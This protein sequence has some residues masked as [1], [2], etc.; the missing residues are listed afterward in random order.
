MAA[1]SSDEGKP[2][3]TAKPRK[4]GTSCAAD[5]V[6]LTSS[7][8]KT[9]K[10]TTP[11]SNAAV[12]APCK[13]SVGAP[14]R[15]RFAPLAPIVPLSVRPPPNSSNTPPLRARFDVGPAD[16][17][18]GH[19]RDDRGQRGGRVDVVRDAQRTSQRRRANPARRREDEYDRGAALRTGP[20]RCR[21]AIIRRQAAS[22]QR[23]TKQQKE[24]PDHQ[25]QQKQHQ[26]HAEAQ[27]FGKAGADLRRRER[28]G[29]AAHQS[30]DA[31]D[32]GA[33]GHASST[34]T[35]SG[36]PSSSCSRPRAS[37][38][39]IAAAAVLLIH[40]GKQ[41]R[42]PEQQGHGNV[43]PGRSQAQ[44]GQREPAVQSLAMQ[45]SGQRE[46]SHEQEDDRVRKRR[47]RRAQV[48]QAREHGQQGDE[49]RRR[50]G[51]APASST[52][53]R[54]ART[55]PARC[56]GRK[57]AARCRRAAPPA[58][59]GRAHVAEIPRATSCL[60]RRGDQHIGAALGEHMLADAARQQVLGCR[61]AVLAEQDQAA[62]L[63]LLVF[64]DAL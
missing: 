30:A 2:S 4:I 29:R 60:T 49:Q 37:G 12:G 27:P 1:A 48:R 50:P 17:T 56:A 47:Q 46:A 61:L 43:A 34:T 62:V 41:R 7:V 16:G 42:Q 44:H 20:G 57:A 55:A 15:K 40:I 19:Q 58:Q 53:G 26:R 36:G 9:T 3:G 39:I 33:V 21:R 38:S 14:A 8:R 5:A 64:D 51:A 52:D 10:V 18:A 23:R 25:P 59:R 63:R 45:R 32:A 6:S 11:S 54:S 24:H 35:R 28:V 31:A 13:A 22:P